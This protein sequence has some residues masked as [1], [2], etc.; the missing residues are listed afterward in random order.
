LANLNFL[1]FLFVLVTF[2]STAY[3]Q[4]NPIIPDRPGFSTGAYTVKPGR[5]YLEFGYQYSFNNHNMDTSTHTTH[6]SNLRVGIIKKIEFDLLWDGWNIDYQEDSNPETSV[7][8]ASVGGKYW[9]IEVD[10]FNLT[11]LGLLSLS[12]GSS[13]STSGHVDPLLGLLWDYSL[14]SSVSIFVNLLANSDV[15]KGDRNY[16]IQPIVGVS[17][18]HT[19]RLGTYLE[20]NSDIPLHT[21]GA[22][23]PGSSSVQNTINGGVTYL[24]TDDIQ[25]DINAGV[26][27]DSETDNFI[28]TGISI[29]F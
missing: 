21:G 11:A 5:I 7:A 18:C 12:V 28:G 1:F 22:S 26:G 19:S 2:Q 8:D 20:Y 24:L 15:T 27:L 4:T 17:F 6:L 25:L 13:P 23:E 9:I 3:A 14:S 10:K 29:R 16:S